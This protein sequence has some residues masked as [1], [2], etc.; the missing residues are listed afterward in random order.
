[1]YKYGFLLGNSYF[2]FTC[3]AHS[4]CSKNRRTFARDRVIG[5]DSETSIAIATEGQNTSG[6]GEMAQ[7]DEEEVRMWREEDGPFIVPEMYARL[8]RDDTWPVHRFCNTIPP[9][10]PG[11]HP[12]F[13]ASNSL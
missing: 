11:K 6:V 13:P 4:Q 5:C 9:Q 3:C 8:L 10:Y 1:M 2:I 12:T 7:A